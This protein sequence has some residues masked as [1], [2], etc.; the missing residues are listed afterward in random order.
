[1]CTTGGATSIAYSPDPGNHYY[2]IVPRNLSFEGSYGK[3][4]HGV[5]RPQGTASCGGQGLA[6]CP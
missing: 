5:E 2:L 4:S 3:D 6:A 1:L